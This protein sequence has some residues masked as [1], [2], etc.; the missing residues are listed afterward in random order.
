MRL[1]SEMI[2]G[3]CKGFEKTRGLAVCLCA[4]PILASQFHFGHWSTMQSQSGPEIL[5]LTCLVG[6]QVGVVP[7]GGFCWQLFHVIQWSKWRVYWQYTQTF[8]RSYQHISSYIKCYL[9]IFHDKYQYHYINYI[10]PTTAVTEV[11]EDLVKLC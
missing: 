1:N 11:P 8:Q 2:L 9:H 7:T 3:I 5:P 10:Y 6:P 4:N